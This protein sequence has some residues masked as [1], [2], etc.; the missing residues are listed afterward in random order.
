MRTELALLLLLAA[1]P[2]RAEDWLQSARRAAASAAI[3]GEAV[4]DQEKAEW[5]PYEPASR[6][7]RADLP[8]SGWTPFEEDDALGTVVRVLGPDEASGALRAT[9]TVRL[10]DRDSPSFIPAKEAV[11]AMRTQE[12]GRESTAVLPLR[13]SAGLA[14]VFEITENRRVPDAGPSAP[15]ELHQYVAVIPRGEAYFVV[16]LVTAREDYLDFREFFVRFLKSLRPV[17]D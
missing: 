14:R 16:R 13:V 9:L 7:F 6:L 12:R 17:G 8:S 2:G 11:D 4:P 1:V 15:L 3:P 10:V 5:M